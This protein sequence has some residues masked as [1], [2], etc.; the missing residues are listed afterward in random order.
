VS[1][2]V[3]NRLLLDSSLSTAVSLELVNSCRHYCCTANAML[4]AAD[5]IVPLERLNFAVICPPSPPTSPSISPMISRSTIA[6]ED[7]SGGRL[8]T[9][10]GSPDDASA[11]SYLA[12]YINVSGEDV[13]ALLRNRATLGT[14]E[15]LT[16]EN[17]SMLGV[18]DPMAAIA[19]VRAAAA[20]GTLRRFKANAVRAGGPFG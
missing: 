12:Q 15:H 10:E 13:R 14:L 16:A 6:E 2:G 20:L 18:K 19:I 9:G 3:T 7:Q 5:V 8:S 17:I 11:L 1:N 4:S